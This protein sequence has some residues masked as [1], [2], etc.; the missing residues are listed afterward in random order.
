MDTPMVLDT[1]PLTCRRME[2]IQISFHEATRMSF[3]MVYKRISTTM[4]VQV[5]LCE[6]MSGINSTQ[7]CRRVELQE[8]CH[9]N[10]SNE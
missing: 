3:Q 1:I 7:C 10:S 5:L 6:G 2:F 4:M 8:V 9:I